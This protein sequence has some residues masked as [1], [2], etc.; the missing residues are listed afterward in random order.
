MRTRLLAAVLGL[1]AAGLLV[2]ASAPTR[3]VA[4]DAPPSIVED[5]SYPGAAQI[6]AQQ[7]V[8]LISGDGHILL[9]DCATPPEGDIGLLKVWT[10]DEQIGADG[11][12]RVCFK[13]TARTGLLNLEVPGVYEIRGDGQ[14]TGTGHEV[15]AELRSDEGEEI[16]VE[17]DP[18]GST[19]VGLGADPDA[20]PTMLLRLTVAG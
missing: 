19:Q 18:D 1:G 20:S 8:K 17:V 2:G 11:I 6:L 4:D 3:A 10:T 13:V 9:A 5:F 7:N 12:G 15:T 14:R 16:T